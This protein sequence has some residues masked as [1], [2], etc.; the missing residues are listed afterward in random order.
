LFKLGLPVEIQDLMPEAYRSYCSP[1]VKFPRFAGADLPFGTILL[2]CLMPPVE[3]LESAERIFH[4][5]MDMVAKLSEALGTC[6]S[7]CYTGI[8]AEGTESPHDLY[9]RGFRFFFSPQPEKLMAAVDYILTLCAQDKPAT[10]A[11]RRALYSQKVD[12]RYRADQN[13]YRRPHPVL[14]DVSPLPDGRLILL[15]A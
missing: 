14:E 13:G 11:E 5:Y 6:P 2:N 7:A 12:A 4:V 10:Q 8:K 1:Q 3:Q 15:A 9:N